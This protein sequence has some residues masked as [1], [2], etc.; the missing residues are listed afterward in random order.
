MVFYQRS[1]LLVLLLCFLVPAVRAETLAEKVR[2]A[3]FP[4]G[5]RLLVVERHD[6]PTFAAYISIGVGSVNEPE[7]ARGV[8]HLLEHMLFKGTKQIGTTDYMAE[9]PILDAIEKVG[10]RLDALRSNTQADAGEIDRLQKRLAE[11]QQEHKHYVVKDE[12]SR[13][14]AENGGVG[15]NAFTSKD[16]TSYVISLPSNRLELWAAV[17]SDRMRNAVLREF[18]T[19]RE[20]IREERRRSYES[21][22]SGLLY[23]HLLANA[24][25]VHPYR[26]PIIGWDT[27]IQNLS[28]TETRTF[29]ERYYAPVNTVITLVGDVTLES[30]TQIVERYFGAIPAGTP[31]PRVVTVEPPQN[32]E[33]RLAVEFDAEP[34]LSMAFHKPTLPERADYVFDIIDLLLSGGTSSRLY[35]ALVVEQGLAASVST[36]TA[37]G[38][39]Y[40]NLFIVSATPRFP[41]TLAEVEAGIV[42]ELKRLADTPVA[43]DE[44]QRVRQRLRADLLRALRSN[45][46]LA[47]MISHYQTV[48][49][50]WRYL[51][52]YP[53]IIET[54]TAE[55][56]QQVAQMYFRNEN[57]T[58]ARLGREVSP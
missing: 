44:L 30:A 8:A 39:R 31:V 16:Q 35:R 49:G 12:F 56:I 19:E 21:S 42:A 7:N 22:P 13:I 1:L 58:V 47:R 23:E 6:S 33:K 34:L 17:E 18:Y 28:L 37:P 3:A 55:D 9:K 24:F 14:Y 43:D 5:L 26:N 52:D 57:R 11:L 41:H 46:G 36:Y 54:I 25:T 53:S 4:N 20:V 45:N 32:G 2:E 50:D 48:A 15:Y 38:S 40:P 10:D 27:D 51:V 29:H